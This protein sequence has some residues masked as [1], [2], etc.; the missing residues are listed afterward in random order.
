MS[1][2]K[3]YSVARGVTIG[4][5]TEWSRCEQSVHR[6]KHAVFKGF[7]SLDQA[8][9]FLLA[10]STFSSCNQIP[11]FDETDNPKTPE[12][13]GHKCNG[14][15]CTKDTCNIDEQ[16]GDDSDNNCAI[17]EPLSDNEEETTPKT[18]MISEQTNTQTL[19][20]DIQNKIIPKCTTCEQVCDEFMILCSKCTKWTHYKCTCL[21]SYQL[22]ILTTSSRK[23]TCESCSKVP[24]QFKDKWKP[25]K[26]NNIQNVNTEN[27]TKCT[28]KDDTLE[29]VSRIEQSVVQAITNTHE[30]CKDD[31]I[32]L[33]QS[34]IEDFK[35]ARGKQLNELSKQLDEI[36]SKCE[37]DRP[38]FDSKIEN[39]IKI[40]HQ[41]I[42]QK[43]LNLS[44]ENATLKAKLENEKNLCTLTQ[45]IDFITQTQ[46]GLTD[47]LGKISEKT[48]E[49]TDTLKTTC[50][51]MLI[52]AK[53]NEIK[54][55]DENN[56]HVSHKN[57]SPRQPSRRLENNTRQHTQENTYL[58][59]T[60]NRFQPLLLDEDTISINSDNYKPTT[61]T[62]KPLKQ[63]A[64][65][66]NSHIKNL[67]T[68]YLLNGCEVSKF[69][70][71]SFEEA[72]DKVE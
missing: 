38:Y 24:Q 7:K 58:I 72:K 33:L 28:N 35:F 25:I 32:S 8:I 45:K 34:Q 61:A 26:S 41:N 3:F 57:N 71:Y 56:N 39:L 63:V 40:Q 51:A 48:T 19:T 29:I 60:Q 43:V 17:H 27:C 2:K 46:D 37:T 21:P 67:R 59:D 30:S 16:E 66:G 12:H 69:N 15:H 68:N 14:V 5:F 11:V 52:C 70:V 6:F 18:F 20:D 64:V 22:F 1:T 49:M 44:K 13:F 53:S 55:N 62:I 10:G 36:D 42:D 65:V 31:Q 9:N 54:R 4:I 23:Y 50:E 47:A